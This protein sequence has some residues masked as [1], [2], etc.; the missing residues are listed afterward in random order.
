MSDRIRFR[1]YVKNAQW[2]MAHLDFELCGAM[3]TAVLD[4]QLLV[5]EITISDIIMCGINFFRIKSEFSA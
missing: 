3:C 4:E 2:K 5:S 1:R